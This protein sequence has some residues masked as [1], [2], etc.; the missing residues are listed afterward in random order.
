MV[1][2]ILRRD[3]DGNGLSVVGVLL[4]L[5][6]KPEELNLLGEQR[7][8]EFQLKSRKDSFQ[9]FYLLNGRLSCFQNENTSICYWHL[10]CHGW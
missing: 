3:G 7:T 10:K 9:G 4:Q 8:H 1:C 6:V 2:G 5:V